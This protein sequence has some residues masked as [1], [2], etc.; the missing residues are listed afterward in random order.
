MTTAAWDGKT[1]ASDSMS[2]IGTTPVNGQTKILALRR[3]SVGSGMLVACAG[4][5]GQGMRL[6]RSF[7]ANWRTI[8]QGERLI[9]CD[10][11]VG[12]DGATVILVVIRPTADRLW[13]AYLI[14]R[15]GEIT[16]ITGRKWAIGSGGEFAM[17]AMA[18]DAGAIKA[19]RIAAELDVHTNN[20]PQSVNVKDFINLGPSEFKELPL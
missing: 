19:V 4:T 17:G 9:S 5:W 12:E 13:T 1:L 10:P 16:D 7:C 11:V 18:M 8:V 20:V 6:V 3:P 14:T 15:D 2:T